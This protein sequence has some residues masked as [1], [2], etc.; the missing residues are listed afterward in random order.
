M[1]FNNK[2]GKSLVGGLLVVGLITPSF[3]STV[4]YLN[5]DKEMSSNLK[6]NIEKLESNKSLAFIR[7]NVT[8]KN[9]KAGESVSVKGKVTD[10]FGGAVTYVKVNMEVTAPN[11]KKITKTAYTNYSGDVNFDVNTGSAKSGRYDV[12][13]QISSYIYK[14]AVANTYFNV[15]GGGSTTEKLNIA[16]STDKPS[17]KLGD[18]AIIT[19]TATKDGQ[20][21]KNANLK[22]RVQGPNNLDASVNKTTDYSGKSQVFFRPKVEGTY[23][24]SVDGNFAGLNAHKSFKMVFGKD[25]VDPQPDENIFLKM[26]ETSEAQRLIEKNENNSD[27]VIFDV[28]TKDEYNEAHIK[29]AI[30]HD[31]Y[32]SDLKAYLRTLDKEK[33]YLVYCR[34]KNRSSKAASMMKQM[35][36]KHLYYINGGMSKWIR[37]GRPVVKPGSEQ[38]S[39]YKMVETDEGQRMIE[40]NKNNKEFVLLDVR[41]KAEYLE[42]HIKGCINHDYYSDDI[43]EFLKTLDRDK[44]YLVYCRTQN[45]SKK[46]TKIMKDLGFKYLYYMNG[47]MTKWLKEGRPAVMPEYAK[48]LDCNTTV[49]KSSYRQG[50]KVKVKFLVTDLEANAIRKGKIEYKLYGPNNSLIKSEKL[51]MGNH[52]EKEV[53]ID[54]GYSAAKGLY[55]LISTGSKSGF[56]GGRAVSIFRVGESK[57]FKSFEQRENAGQYKH[58]KADDL[59]YDVLKKHYGK[60]LYQYMVKDGK[61]NDKQLLDVID[62]NKNSVFVFG[63]P[64]CGACVDMLQDMG[65]LPHKSYNYLEII[66]SVEKN[67]QETVDFT[68]NV[69]KKLGIT[70]LKSHIVYDANDTIWGSRLG[71]LTTPNTVFLDENGRIVNMAGALDGKGLYDVY[72]KTF[73]ERP[74][75]SNDK[76]NS[77]IELKI[78]KRTVA[79]GDTVKATAKVKH[80]FTYQKYVKVNYTL[81]DPNGKEF[82]ETKYTNWNG[83]AEFEYR[84]ARNAVGGEYTLKAELN[85]YKLTAKPVVA[86]FRVKKADAPVG[87]KRTY[88]DRKA[89][90][91]F[92]RIA[93]KDLASKLKRVYGVN[94]NHHTITNLD[95]KNVT[96]GDV[97][98]GKRPSVIALGVPT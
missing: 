17:Y 3:A 16:Y 37:E 97:M 11:G 91:E 49:D 42:S 96:V 34:T 41:T 89:N 46:A 59:E 54:L 87:N 50:E 64:G 51:V 19:F 5:S 76:F 36:F 65:K 79:A 44:T 52:G 73:G 20:A 95:G 85:D 39:F 28:R 77:E 94:V 27:F 60:N 33:T 21:V 47:G 30:N 67:V 45:R 93:G 23:T 56:E 13:L 31:Y 55:K 82:K 72:E 75:D 90:G 18:K 12:K 53:T 26:V 1:K 24:I 8:P 2:L 4:D 78:K 38:D 61:L 32:S 7:A 66:T 58:F 15:S 74:E 71:F 9:V 43:K 86:K 25:N 68:E 98:D 62:T 6:M 88:Q 35:G 48:I 69:L 10:K 83:D 84:L 81:I 57:E 92:S 40:K 80:D 22:V 63:Y 29:G 70:H 14:N